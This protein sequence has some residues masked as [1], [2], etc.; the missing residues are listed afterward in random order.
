MWTANREAQE[1][2]LSAPIQ[3]DNLPPKVRGNIRAFQRDNPSAN[4]ASVLTVR[5]AVEYYLQWEGIINYTDDLLFMF[6]SI[7]NA[8]TETLTSERGFRHG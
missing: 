2:I 3:I 1:A 8:G 6:V 7:W 4:Q 5:E